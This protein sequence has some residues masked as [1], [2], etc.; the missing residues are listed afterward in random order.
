VDLA[1]YFDRCYGFECSYNALAMLLVQRPTHASVKPCCAIL[2]YVSLPP[3][4]HWRV[5]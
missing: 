3:R 5:A 4:V 2:R 1:V